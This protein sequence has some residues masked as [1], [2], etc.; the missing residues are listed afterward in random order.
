MNQ[1]ST[2][3]RA[4]RPGGRTADVTARIHSAILKLLVDG[5]VRA[6]TFSAIA[7]Q[8]EVERSTLYRRFADPWDAIIDAVM[9]RVAAQVKPDFGDTFADDLFSVL[10]KLRDMLESALGPAVVAAAAEFRTR[11]A[12][13]MQRP[14]FDRRMEQLAPM[15]DAAIARDELRSDVDREALFTFAAGP[16]YFRMFIASREVD[17]EFIH[18]VVSNVCWL[19]CSPS[20]A[21]KLSLPARIL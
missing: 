7:K 4:P 17:D 18:A 16:I 14:F 11:S 3:R 19:Y 1:V 5:G 9:E 2:T 15:F 10:R 8:A 12:S 13:E 6:C 21:A 20:V